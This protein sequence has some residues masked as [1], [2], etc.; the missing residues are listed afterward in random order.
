L[1]DKDEREAEVEKIT[2]KAAQADHISARTIKAINVK[3]QEDPIYYR[4]MAD[5]IKETITAY[6]QKRIDEAEYLKRAIEFE[7]KFFNGRSDDAPEELANNEA[8]LAFY[9]FSLAIFEKEELLKTPYHIEVGLAIDEGVKNH[10]FVDG[11]KIIDWHNNDDILGAINIEIGDKIYELHQ[12]Y[13]L[14]TDWSK[15]DAIIEECI[16]VAKIKYS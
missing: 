16:K 7:D 5:L 9:N 12:K 2:G 13:D 4:K 6:H 14:D 8:A 15:I 11:Q 10:S 1:F 3:M